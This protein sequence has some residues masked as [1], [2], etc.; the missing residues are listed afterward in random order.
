MVWDGNLGSFAK[1]EP[2]A[3][4]VKHIFP[5]RIA[6]ATLLLKVYLWTEEVTL[7]IGDK[8]SLCL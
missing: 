7:E 1:V 5:S 3:L 8:D 2:G 6:L 4:P